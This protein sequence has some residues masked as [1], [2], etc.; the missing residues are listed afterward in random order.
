MHNKKKRYVSFPFSSLRTHRDFLGSHSFIHNVYFISVHA[1]QGAGAGEI[2]I[3]VREGVSVFLEFAVG[4][5]TGNF[6]KVNCLHL[7]QTHED[8]KPR[9]EGVLGNVQ[10]RPLRK[11]S[12]DWGGLTLVRA[13]GSPGTA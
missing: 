7:K 11:G 6:A 4:H 13:V 12:E 3:N 10:E 1:G 5:R 9:Y 8:K 2:S